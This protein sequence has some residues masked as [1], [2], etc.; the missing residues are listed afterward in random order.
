MGLQ[1]DIRHT[2][3]VT[4]VALTGRVTLGEEASVLRDALREVAKEGQKNVLLD[5]NGVTYLDSTG[6]GVL[7]SSFATITNAGGHLK[8][9]NL[10]SRVKDLLLITKLYAVFEIFDDEIAAAAS[11]FEP[12]AAV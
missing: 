5:L 8:L 11:F 2:N 9:V 12:A 1:V 10:N 4:V 3:T 7:V 6:L